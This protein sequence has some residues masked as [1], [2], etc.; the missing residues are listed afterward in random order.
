MLP[1]NYINGS[2]RWQNGRIELDNE[3]I[4]S[5]DESDTEKLPQ[6]V[7]ENSG[8]HYPKFFKMDLL[9]KVAFLSTELLLR[10]VHAAQ[11]YNKERIAVVLTT[12]QG[13]LEVDKRYEE[14]RQTFA[15]PALF[16]Y[17]LPNIML[18]EICI[19]NGFKGEQACN[20]SESEDAAFLDF[21]VN[22]LLNNRNME[23]C[24]CGFADATDTHIYCTLRWVDKKEL[25]DSIVFNKNNILKTGLHS[26]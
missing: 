25:S 2:I 14:S 13:C 18:G 8:I 19:R 5:S 9:S 3:V 26:F 24:L 12:A 4:F 1:S 22:D 15:S 16:V 7:Y 10:N 23:A 17:T 21:Y 6:I 20:I 11:Q